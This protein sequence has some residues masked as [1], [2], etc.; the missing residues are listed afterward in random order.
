MQQPCLSAIRLVRSLLFGASLLTALLTMSASGIAQLRVSVTVAPPPL[1]VYEQPPCPGDDYIWAPGYW[2]YADDDYY[3]VPGTWVLAPEPG[4]LWTPGWWGWDNDSFIFHEGYW[5]PTVGFYGGIDY[6]FGYF[7]RGFDGGRWDHDHF[8]YNRSV[9]NVN[10]TNVH[11]VYNQSV[12][13]R[14]MENRVSYNGGHGGVEA[15]PSHEEESAASGRRLPPVAAQMH[16][17][18]A[19]R[20]DPG[21][22]VSANQGGPAVAATPRPGDLHDHA[23]IPARGREPATNQGEPTPRPEDNNA[24]RPG[25]A[26]VHPNDLPAYQRPAAPNTGNAKMDQKYQQQQDKLYEQQNKDRQKLE[27]KQER[28]HQKLEQKNANDAAR[29]QVEQRHSQQTQQLQQKQAQQQQ[30]MEQRQAPSHSNGGPPKK[31]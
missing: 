8:F 30:H 9:T 3:W 17:L 2:A 27:Q 29:Q 24:S 18:E 16:H 23:A 5:G 4:L 15:R 14:V 20:R 7:G 12:S 10:V 22:H 26:V 19:A 6:G 28:D 25:K 31:H 13:N 1:L 11:N 21:Q